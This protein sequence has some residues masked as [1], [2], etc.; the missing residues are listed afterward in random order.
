M[1]ANSQPFVMWR[2][3]EIAAHRRDFDP[4]AL[5]VEGEPPPPELVVTKARRSAK[6]KHRP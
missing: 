1:N 3:R 4:A 6:G 2:N 5:R